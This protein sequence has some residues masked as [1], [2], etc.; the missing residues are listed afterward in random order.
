MSRPAPAPGGRTD[1][2]RYYRR[3]S[4]FHAVL[5]RV[6]CRAVLGYARAYAP[7]RR[8]LTVIEFG[9]GN[10]AFYPAFAAAFELGAYIAVDSSPAG[11]EALRRRAGAAAS[12]G[13]LQL[14][15]QDILGEPLP[16]TGDIALSVGLI[17]HFS[18]TDLARAVASHVAPLRDGGLVIL[19]FPTP[20]W[21]YR[22]VRGAAEQLGRWP[23]PD[24]TPLAGDAV[25]HLLGPR[26]RLLKQETLWSIGVTQA[27]V[28]ARRETPG[29]AA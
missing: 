24:E 17:E 12:G 4:P 15:Q 27:Y 9:G 5:E 28:V 26:C 16:A 23:F 20:T 1:W 7:A 21:L 3:P 10:S 22:L 25:A 8:P 13:V 19:G 2:D 14:R 18:G 11:L 29:G 6:V